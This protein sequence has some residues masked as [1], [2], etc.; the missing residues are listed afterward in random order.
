MRG[1]EVLDLELVALVT[2]QQVGDVGIDRCLLM[3]K[4][5]AHLFHIGVEEL[6]D[7]LAG[8]TGQHTGNL[9]EVMRDV[10]QAAVEVVVVRAQ[11]VRHQP[12]HGCALDGCQRGDVAVVAVHLANEQEE[13]RVDAVLG[14]HLRYRL[15]AKSHGDAKVRQREQQLRLRRDK[16]RQVDVL[17][18][19]IVVHFGET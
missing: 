4:V 11:Q 3:D 18:V 7:G 8:A 2:A 14:T 6:L 16:C 19:K 5:L 9:L 1:E 15:V 13:L 10:R 17:V 12:L